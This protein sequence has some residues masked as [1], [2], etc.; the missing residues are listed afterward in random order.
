[1]GVARAEKKSHGAIE[2]T[3]RSSEV[4]IPGR[5]SLPF[6]IIA[7]P[8]SHP[9]EA[10]WDRLV[11]QQK[12]FRLLAL[13]TS[14]E[15]FGST[16]EREVQFN[17][18]TWDERLRNPLATT[19]VALEESAISE[20][21]LSNPDALVALAANNDWLGTVV[22]IGPTDT[23]TTL[24]SA[25]ASAVALAANAKKLDLDGERNTQIPHYQINAF[26]VRPSARGRGL[27]TALVSGAIAHGEAFRREYG[28]AT[29]RF[30]LLV[31]EDNGPA[32]AAYQR[33]GFKVIGEDTYLKKLAGRE[34]FE[35]TALTL[36]LWSRAEN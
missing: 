27:G 15:Y 6:R 17:D 35:K 23:A 25:K 36:E 33:A 28:F 2:G 29:A 20:S 12:D 19:L 8:R 10:I 5:G 4:G 14:P 3:V 34:Q 18:A 1:M 26:F 21:S 24:V 30:T 31:D 16:Y 7:L 9:D 22:L 11:Q 13:K 32:N